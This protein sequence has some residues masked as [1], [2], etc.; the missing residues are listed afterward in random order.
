ML[1]LCPSIQ[2]PGGFLSTGYQPSGR[3]NGGKIDVGQGSKKRF[4]VFPQPSQLIATRKQSTFRC[5][6][7]YYLEVGSETQVSE[8]SFWKN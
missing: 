7:I 6:C 8:Y 2:N 3:C 4:S 1:Y 5:A